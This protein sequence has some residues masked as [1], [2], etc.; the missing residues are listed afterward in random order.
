MIMKLFVSDMT[1]T[2]GKG[3]EIRGD[4]FHHE[5]HTII[6]ISFNQYV[7]WNYGMY[8]RREDLVWWQRP[9]VGS[10]TFSNLG[11]LILWYCHLSEM[12]C[13]CTEHLECTMR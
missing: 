2:L 12:M 5:R 10:K 3:D 1:Q 11:I 8:Q 4:V 13:G 7:A 6:V 9:M